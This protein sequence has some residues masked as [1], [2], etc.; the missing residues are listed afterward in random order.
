M[1]RWCSLTKWNNLTQTLVLV[2]DNI[3]IDDF[4]NNKGIFSET[5]R[6]FD[7]GVEMN[8]PKSDGFNLDLAL[9]YVPISNGMKKRVLAGLLHYFFQ[10]YFVL[11]QFN[12]ETIRIPI[13][14]SCLSR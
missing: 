9:A 7:D 3:S 1:F 14:S 4:E 13:T 10:F 2:V 6:I 11:I 5:H 8:N 12:L